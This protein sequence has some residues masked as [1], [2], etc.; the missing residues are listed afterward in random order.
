MTARNHVINIAY[1]YIDDSLF[2]AQVNGI[3]LQRSTNDGAS[4]TKSQPWAAYKDTDGRGSERP[5][6]SDDGTNIHVTWAD[7]GSGWNDSGVLKGNAGGSVYYSR[8]SDL[9]AT[10][11][12]QRIAVKSDYG[13]VLYGANRPNVHS[14]GN[15]IVAIVVMADFGNFIDSDLWIS[16]SANNG[17]TWAAPRRIGVHPGNG[18]GL[19]HPAISGGGNILSVIATTADSPNGH[20]RETHS[21]DGGATWSAVANIV[22]YA[23]D[24]ASD[25]PWIGA[26]AGTLMAI[27]DD[28]TH[29]SSRMV[30]NPFF[31][32]IP[33]ITRIL[34]NCTRADDTTPPPGASWSGT[35]ISTAGTAGEGLD[36]VAN[37]LQWHSG[38]GFRQ[39]HIWNA[40]QGGADVEY[41]FIVAGAPAVSNDKITLPIRGLSLNTG[42]GSYY[43]MDFN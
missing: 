7:S 33:D 34:D 29:G 31:M 2:F 9:G 36:L 1:S 10:W 32:G 13:P 24:A 40:Q 3:M 28:P 19:S 25:A 43:S 39:G 20:L 42:S 8:S 22:T 18:V 5:T 41:G 26:T 35:Q 30:R 14:N 12:T 6:I 4:W 11:V 16:L 37:K 38:G 27:V 23:T 17:T 21:L 15:G